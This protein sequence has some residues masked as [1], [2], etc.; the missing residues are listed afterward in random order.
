MLKQVDLRKTLA[1]LRKALRD[2]EFALDLYR[3]TAGSPDGRVAVSA[4]RAALR[5]AKE[6]YMK[7]GGQ[8]GDV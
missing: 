8:R 6:R 5:N 7:A 1:E 2:A 4:A 3:R